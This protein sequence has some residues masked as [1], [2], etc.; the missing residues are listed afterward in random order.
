MVTTLPEAGLLPAGSKI[1][2]RD[3]AR[4]GTR[5]GQTLLWSGNF[6]PLCAAASSASP[7]VAANLLT[8]ACDVAPE[9]S[10][11]LPRFA[12]SAAATRLT[13]GRPISLPTALLAATSF[14][15][16]TPVEIPMPSSM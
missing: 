15:M 16:S 9:G 1:F 8:V 14:A 2:G 4:P 5:R 12:L 7:A 13:G 3:T 11:L 6:R 10:Y